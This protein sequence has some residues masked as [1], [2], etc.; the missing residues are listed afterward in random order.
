MHELVVIFTCFTW[1]LWSFRPWQISFSFFRS[2]YRAKELPSVQW[3]QQNNPCCLLELVWGAVACVLVHAW[4]LMRRA[5]MYT[6]WTE[7]SPVSELNDLLYLNDR[8]DA[9]CTKNGRILRCCCYFFLL[10]PYCCSIRFHA[11]YMKIIDGLGACWNAY[12]NQFL[13]FGIWYNRAKK[14]YPMMPLAE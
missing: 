9:S 6:N 13:L 3:M 12:E 7:W 11:T 14:G 1:L 8:G 5:S 2:S 10:M 4:C